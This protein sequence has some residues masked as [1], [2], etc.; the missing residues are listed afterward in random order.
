MRHMPRLAKDGG[1]RGRLC[2][3]DS[4]VPPPM[5]GPCQP[6]AKLGIDFIAHHALQAQCA[7]SVFDALSS[8]FHCR[9]R[10]GADQAADGDAVAAVLLDHRA[11][12]PRLRKSPQG[13]QS[14]FH[15]SHDL[16]DVGVYAD[17][18]LGDFDAI[19][20]PGPAHR[21]AARTALDRDDRIVEIGWPKFDPV[22]LPV[23]HSEFIGNL[24]TLAPEP[25]VLY[26]PTWP[27]TWEWRDLLPWLTTMPCCVLVK[28]HILVDSDQPF[29]PGE[30]ARYAECRRSILAMEAHV[31]SLPST[32]CRVAPSTMNLCT[33]FP[34]IDLLIT[35]SSSCA[36]EFAPFGLSIETGRTGAGDNPELDFDPQGSRLCSAVRCLSL[37][38][39]KARMPSPNAFLQFIAGDELR[40]ADAAAKIIA[41]RPAGQIGPGAAA[42]IAAWMDLFP[43]GVPQFENSP[44]RPASIRLRQAL[45]H[46]WR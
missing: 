43:R 5:S 27:N 19:L 42:I 46:F 41:P 13:Y 16:G 29:P 32:K 3:R 10:L 35:D 25:V 17:E 34:R 21:D 38:E 2:I 15:M 28:N 24:S 23:E 26:A 4:V 6:A 22:Q 18:W 37:A 8:R 31:R 45:N 9:W 39:M 12:H 1:Y 40:S 30:E 7:E 11:F 20:V 33:L 14:L 44:R 36:M